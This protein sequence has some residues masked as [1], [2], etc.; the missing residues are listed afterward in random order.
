[1]EVKY[2]A[3]ISYQ[4]DSVILA[5]RIY[6]NLKADGIS[7]FLDEY[8][9]EAGQSIP[10]IIRNA[11][12]SCEYIICLVTNAWIESEYCNLEIDSIIMEGSKSGKKTI[13]PLLVEKG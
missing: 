13:I 5:R 11:M 6:G 7:T 8:S 4:H 2:K 10:T 1:M 3:F 12:R 9:I